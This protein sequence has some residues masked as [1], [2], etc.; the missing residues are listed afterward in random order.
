MKEKK[1]V[2]TVTEK[3]GSGTVDCTNEGFT[4][5]EI[6]GMLRMKEEDILAQIKYPAQFKRYYIDK[7]GKRSEIVKEGEE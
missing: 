2:M 4:A 1:F 7:D 3:D 5:F 6:L